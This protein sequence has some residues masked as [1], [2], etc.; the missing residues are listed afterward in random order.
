MCGGVCLCFALQV[1]VCPRECVC[2]GGGHSGLVENEQTAGDTPRQDRILV[3]A[4]V[5]AG[6]GDGEGL[7][8]GEGD[9]I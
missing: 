7:E 6:R 1:K 2:V 4:L 8:I 9:E 3:P 5:E